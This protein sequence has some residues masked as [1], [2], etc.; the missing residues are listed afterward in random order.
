M[1]NDSA[2]A[3]CIVAKHDALHGVHK[4]LLRRSHVKECVNHS[5]KQVF[6]PVYPVS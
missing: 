1:M 6:L 4:N 2:M 5:N 3:F